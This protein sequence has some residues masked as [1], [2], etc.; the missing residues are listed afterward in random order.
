MARMQLIEIHDQEWLPRSLR[1]AVTD[2]LQFALNVG[3][4]YR[5]IVPHL[6]KALEDAKTQ[7]IVDLCSGGGGPWLRLHRVFEEEQ[8]YPVEVRLTDKY[9]NL[10]AFEHARIASRDRIS[11][12]A[13][14]VDATKS[15]A[16]LNGFRTFFTSF[17]HFR[18][19]DARAILQDAVRSRQGIGIFEI[20]QRRPL[21]V[22]LAVVLPPLSALV[23]APF[24]RPF[25]WS[26]LLLTYLIPIVPFVLSFDGIVSCL[27]TYS[28]QELSALTEGLSACGYRWEVGEERGGLSPVPIT[29]LIGH[30]NRG[31]DARSQQ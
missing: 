10:R 18:P 13:D 9:P 3:N 28:P 17:H 30:P 7:K 11:F 2:T 20:P 22:A 12:T 16:D 8:N 27:R 4:L 25:R 23:F 26:R 5:P 15:P 31:D 14:P 1:D 29:Y 24:V 6:R 19:E 21:A